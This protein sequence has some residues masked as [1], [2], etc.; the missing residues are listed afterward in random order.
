MSEFNAHV[1]T[2]MQYDSIIMHHTVCV[3]TERVPSLPAE[4]IAPR[5]FSQSVFIL[6]IIHSQQTSLLLIMS[7][8]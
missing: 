1:Y 2:I 3:H 6:A 4:L 7:P 5:T 8:V